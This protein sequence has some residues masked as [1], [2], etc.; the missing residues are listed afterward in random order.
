M[1][2]SVVSIRCNSLIKGQNDYSDLTDG[3][4]QS[5]AHVVGF[6]AFRVLYSLADTYTPTEH[7]Q[8]HMAAC[9]L[10]HHARPHL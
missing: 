9:V 1:V 10:T 2:V 8:I 5:N 4:R 7:I 6:E 3:R